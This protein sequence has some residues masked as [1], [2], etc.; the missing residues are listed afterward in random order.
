V[1]PPPG[2]ERFIGL[3][4]ATPGLIAG[5]AGDAIEARLSDRTE[6]EPWSPNDVLAH[7]RACQ[8]VRG[9]LVH[10][11]LTR[12]FPV[13]RYVSPRTYIRRTNYPET[14]FAVSLAD[15]AGDRG[16]F[17]QTLRGLQPDQWLRGADLKGRKPESVLDCAR[18]LVQHEA[19]HLDQ[20]RALLARPA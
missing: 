8:D 17:V 19:V 3:L 13:I 5:M 6:A 4:E 7:L 18:Y 20:M 1:Q 14:P 15:F 16:A 10:E 11:M 2:A 12:D 9:K